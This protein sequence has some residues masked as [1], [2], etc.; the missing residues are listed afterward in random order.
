MGHE[1]SPAQ[2]SSARLLEALYDAHPERA[3]NF[4]PPRVSELQD[5]TDRLQTR[6]NELESGNALVSHDLRK[7]QIECGLLKKTVADQQAAIDKLI[8][9][10]DSNLNL[11]GAV[12]S[13]RRVVETVCTFY[14]FKLTAMCGGSRLGSLSRARHVAMYLTRELTGKSFPIIGRAMG[15]RDHTTIMHGHHQITRR[16]QTDERLADEISLIKIKLFEGA[17]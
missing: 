3:G 13:I 12:P 7:A 14:G 11:A 4:R 17:K 2:A 15:D 6:V 10:I 9:E 5:L 8:T 1:L 16:L